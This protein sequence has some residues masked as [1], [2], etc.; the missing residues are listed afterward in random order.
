MLPPPALRGV[1]RTDARARA[2]YAEGAGIYRILPQA[3]VRPVD[4]AD[5]KSLISWATEHRVALVPRG[6]GSAM[7]G[8]NVGDGVGVDL[9]GLAERRL[10]VAPP[11]RRAVTSAAVILA[12]LT[13]A[14][15]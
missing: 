12:E 10:D 15:A 4:L 6:A 5:L 2:A 13:A 9:T 7:G 1:Y 8:G 3:I 14:A 11:A